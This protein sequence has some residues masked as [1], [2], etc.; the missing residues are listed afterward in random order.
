MKG[1]KTTAVAMVAALAVLCAAFATSAAAT[2]TWQFKGKALEGTESILGGAYESSMTVP[3]LT[4]E[5]ENFLY[6]LKIANKSGAGTGE[7]NEMP[8]FECSVNPEE[9]EVAC[10]VGS[11]GA[12]NM[13]WPS[14]LATFSGKN[15]VVIEKVDVG[16]VYAGEECVLNE[17]L[18]S[19]TGSAGGVIDNTKETA[20]F[21]ATTLSQS[22]TS[23]E[24]FGN[25]ID[26]IG[27]F[28]TEAFEWHREE[29]LTVS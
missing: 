29:A 5:C 18:V 26:W 3:G 19:V 1:K 15:Y 11:I 16:I 14:H 23:L 8:L 17:I 7:L 22:K 13:P 20:E 4:T 12:E 9:E 21:N 27:L 2:P 10:T 6:K 28:P 25:E 24:A